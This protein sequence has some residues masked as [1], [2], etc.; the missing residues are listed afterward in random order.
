L[1]SISVQDQ[2][3]K[4]KN[5]GLREA[6]ATKKR[7]QKRSK[8]LDLYQRKEYHSGVVFWSPRL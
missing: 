6:V 4:H 1:H 2:L 7:I 3:L 8:S 5:Q